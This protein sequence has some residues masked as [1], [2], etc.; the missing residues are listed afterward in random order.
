MIVIDDRELRA[1]AREF[2]MLNM[3]S[4]IERVI[5]VAG[6]MVQSRMA[7]YPPETEGNRPGPYP[8]AW[9]QRQFGPRWALKGGGTGGANTSEWLQKAWRTDRLSKL[10]AEVSTVS[11]KGGGEVSYIEYVQSEEH[12]TNVH[13]EH[14]W[15]TD[16]QVADEVEKSVELDRALSAA[17]DMELTSKLG[18]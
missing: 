12:Q 15:Q 7:A 11:P 5:P 16:A 6:L 1:L 18:V 13:R 17:V 10:M 9:Y 8:K 4:V 14:G 3:E 2:A